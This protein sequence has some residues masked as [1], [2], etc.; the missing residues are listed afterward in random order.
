MTDE[1]WSQDILQKLITR[2]NLSKKDSNYFKAFSQL[3]QQLQKPHKAEKNDY[4]RLVNENGKLR[5][6]NESLI[7]SLNNSTIKSETLESKRNQD[8]KSIQH[9]EKSVKSLGQKISNLNMEIGEKNKS[10][11]IINEELLLNQIQV[12]VLND[13]ITKLTNE[14][15]ALIKRWMEKVKLDAEKLND[16]NDK[17]I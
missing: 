5:S 16:A 4:N 11:E 12:N 15:E 13:R 2:D 17:G 14:N 1:D 6:Q 9:L 8:R 10:I 3:S 7:D